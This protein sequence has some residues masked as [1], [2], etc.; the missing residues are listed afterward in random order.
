M[1]WKEKIKIGDNVWSI[2]SLS[3]AAEKYGYKLERL[4]YSIK[5]LLENLL[6][7]DGS[8]FV[9]SDEIKTV[10]EWDA[11]A[12]DRPEISFMPY[13]VILQDFTGVP[14]IV[15][16]AAMR[17]AVAAN[18]KDPKLINP[19]Q[20]SDL[21]IDHSVQVDAFGTP[22]AY[23]INLDM[24][25]KRN[26][27]RYK[28][29]KWGQKALTNFRVV[30]PGTGIVHQVNIE[31]LADVIAEVNDSEPTLIPDTLVGTDSHTT[32]VNGL[33]VLG[34]GV[35]GIEAEAVMLGQPITLIL[36]EVIGVRITGE[37]RE[38]ITAT[39]IVLTITHMLRKYGVVGKFVEFFGPSLKLLQVAD[40]AT[41]GNMSPEYGATCGIFPLDNATINYLK[42][43]ARS[44]EKITIV[45]EYA[46]K[47]KLFYSGEEAE[48]TDV[49]ELD[50]SKVETT[51]SGPKRPQDTVYLSEVPKNFNNYLPELIPPG[52]KETSKEVEVSLNSHKISLKDGK[53][54]IAAI[55]SCT[56]TS[57]PSVMIAAGLLAKKANEKGLNTKEW[58]KTSLAPGSMV[59]TEY[60]YKSGL[61]NELE[62]LG[63]SVVAYGCTT[64]IGN[65][66]PLPKPIEEAVKNNGLVTVSILS[67]NRNFEG[68]VHPLVRANYLASPP[69]VVAYALVGD[70]TV[71]LSKDPLGHAADGTPVYLHDIWPS[72]QEINETIDKYVTPELFE[73][74][75]KNVFK[76]DERW[77]ALDVEIS[78]LYK[79]DSDSTYIRK[80][81]FFEGLTAE[82]PPPPTI[83]KA[84]VLLYLGDTVTTDHISPAGAIHPES[85]A[86]KYLLSKGVPVHEFNTYGS[87]RGNHEVMMRGTFANV[88]IRNK[89]TPGKEGWLTKYIPTGEITSVYEAAMRYKEEGIPTIVIAGKEYGTGSSRDWAAKGPALLGVKAVL[90]E[91]FERIHRSN[92]VGMGILPVEFIDG[93]NATN[94][95]LTGEETFSFPTLAQD[96][97]NIETNKKITT[98]VAE[99]ENGE[100][101]EFKVKM[102]LDTPI[103]VKYYLNGG[104]LHYVLRKILST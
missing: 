42:L 94:L 64:C 96:I 37:P 88:R 73:K 69:L 56:N 4:P 83:E 103:E 80:P 61:L 70:I 30:P 59:V 26:K 54:V 55:T 53:L 33:G 9:N 21:V 17:D 24:E 75:Y 5:I 40:R 36:P 16:F 34:W 31:Y 38:G 1:E 11:K 46:K 74:K 43:T 82:L 90:A 27:E 102:R 29:L 19:K 97:E 8:E 35:G 45:E 63:F 49:L 13:R 65:S 91:S 66:G 101:V 57:N 51:L 23:Y 50:L 3:K 76:G 85:P 22:R 44:P 78:D 12:T 95:N 14:A 2:F 18:G 79:W 47:Q 99:K 87:R 10:L 60:L 48:Y 104:I 39:D 68:R 62:K 93:Q 89:L 52:R 67:G 32:M 20:K 100:K 28:F 98:V 6:R 84:K 81:P 92:L 58:V 41:I 72:L 86:G 25:Y 15:D 77:E 71:N 7:F